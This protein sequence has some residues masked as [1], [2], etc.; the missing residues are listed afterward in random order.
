MT[1]HQRMFDSNVEHRIAPD[2]LQCMTI[3]LAQQ[4]VPG[5]NNAQRQAFVKG[6]LKIGSES[7]LIREEGG[8]YSQ[9]EKDAEDAYWGTLVTWYQGA[10]DKEKFLARLFQLCACGERPEMSGELTETL[11]ENELTSL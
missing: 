3:A 6:V 8:A 7:D 1:L 2:P 5:A 4:W 10:T 9:A 11:V